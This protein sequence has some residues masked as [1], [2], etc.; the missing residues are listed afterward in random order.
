MTMPTVTIEAGRH[1]RR[2]C[3]LQFQAPD[4][5]PAAEFYHLDSDGESIIAE[6][7]GGASLR[8]I[9]PAMRAGEKRTC[10]VAP[11]EPAERSTGVILFCEHG[12]LNILLGDEVVTRYVYADVPARPYFYPLFAPGQTPVTRAYPMYPD[13]RGETRD[14]P[15]HRSLWIAHGEVN[16]IDNWSEQ[17]G[18]GFTRHEAFEQIDIGFVAGSFTARSLWTTPAGDPI[19]T[20]RLAV[21]AWVGGEDLRLLDFDIRLEATH[22]D[23]LFG[24][25]KEGGILSVRVASELDVPRTGRITNVFGGIDESE[26]WGRAAHWC[27]YSGAVGGS[28][29]GI[30]VMDH[31]HSFRYP[32]H[33]HVRNYGLMTANPFGYTAYTGGIKEGSYTLRICESLR[34]RYRVAVHRG[35]CADADIGG[36]Y[37]DFVAP[38]R[39][40]VDGHS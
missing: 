38:P 18:H 9:L 14:H 24:D 1:D 4:G 10:R 40:T 16:G 37:L 33:W 29:V 27:D 22:G 31:P 12:A 34:F 39:V 23:V 35:S 8:T 26:C 36:R 32:T 19:L 2:W 25:T 17:P 20:E 11:A 5:L 15:H 21:T 7:A 3:P 6:P 13:A 28:P 30:A